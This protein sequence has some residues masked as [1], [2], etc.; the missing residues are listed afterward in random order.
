MFQTKTW[1]KIDWRVKI[2]LETC[3][4]LLKITRGRSISFKCSTRR[5]NF[6]C[7]CIGSTIYPCKIKSPV[8]PREYH[9]SLGIRGL[10]LL[11][12]RNE[13]ML[14]LPASDV[15]PSQTTGFILTTPSICHSKLVHVSTRLCKMVANMARYVFGA[16]IQKNRGNVSFNRLPIDIVICILNRGFF[17]L[18]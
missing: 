13:D 1:N 16:P 2:G 15:T 18:I 14:S 7:P 4:D 6:D 12:I 5:N 11:V 9:L 17:F 10:L 8:T 3:F